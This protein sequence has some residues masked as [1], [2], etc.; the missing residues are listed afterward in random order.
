MPTALIVPETALLVPGVSGRTSVLEQVRVAALAAAR[1][2]VADAP[3]R[4]VVVGPAARGRTAD[5]AT[6][7]ASLAPLGVHE[8]HLGWPA[9]CCAGD[10]ESGATRAAPSTAVGLRLLAEAGWAGPTTVVELASDD[11]GAGGEVSDGD[12]LGAGEASASLL[13]LG[14]LSARRDEDSPRASDPRAI[15]LDERLAADLTC[16][17][18]DGRARLRGL[19]RD[20][21]AELGVSGAAPWRFLAQHVEGQLAEGFEVEG[22][23]DAAELALGVDYRVVTWRWSA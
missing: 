2:L 4:V 16:P 23:E 12:A 6:L 22:R 3:A 19:D 8:R 13:V 1:R 5:A 11:D 14:S 17:T 21:A 10:H 20:L 9:P 15:P 18:A 7:C